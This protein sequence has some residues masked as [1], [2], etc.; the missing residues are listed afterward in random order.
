MMKEIKPV[1]T[2]IVGC[3]GISRIF[4]EN[5]TKRFQ[6]IDLVKCCSKGCSLERTTVLR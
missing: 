5:F 6:I 3:G 1:K 2:A 4:F